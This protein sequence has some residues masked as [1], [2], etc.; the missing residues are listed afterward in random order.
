MFGAPLLFMPRRRFGAAGQGVD[1]GRGDR[2][3]V[4]AE[5]GKPDIVEQDDQ[6][7]WRAAL[8]HAE[9]ALWRGRPIGLG[10]AHC[11]ADL[12]RHAFPLCFACC[13]TQGRRKQ[14]VT[15]HGSG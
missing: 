3:A 7:V 5:I 14:L 15:L 11:L 2:R 12:G 13:P 4:A 6:D 10:F 1:G 8:V 9:G